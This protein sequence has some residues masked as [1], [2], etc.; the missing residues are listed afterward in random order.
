MQIYEK[1][2]INEKSHQ[3]SKQKIILRLRQISDWISDV[4]QR[5]TEWLTDWQ[6]GLLSG[7]AIE[8]QK[9]LVPQM[10]L[11]LS[12]DGGFALFVQK[13]PDEY[14]YRNI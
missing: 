4:V 8:S 7:W 12:V 9:E 1:H 3:N 10:A 6:E 5:L 13:W 2:K 11:K 14:K